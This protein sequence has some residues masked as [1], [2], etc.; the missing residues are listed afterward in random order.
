MNEDPYV[1]LEPLTS[2]HIPFHSWFTSLYMQFNTPVSPFIIQNIV[3]RTWNILISNH[4]S[5]FSL[6]CAIIK[7][8]FIT[9]PTYP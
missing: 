2:F 8:V 3:Y 9:Y 4:H 6:V 5:L 1:F 7:S